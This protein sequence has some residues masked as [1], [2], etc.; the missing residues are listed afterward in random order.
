MPKRAALVMNFMPKVFSQ[1]LEVLPERMTSFA[2][3]KGERMRMGSHLGKHAVHVYI[4]SEQSPTEADNKGCCA[5]P[6]LTP[7]SGG[8]KQ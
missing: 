5:A 2:E 4:L 8:L 3:P 7:G 1:T 6:S